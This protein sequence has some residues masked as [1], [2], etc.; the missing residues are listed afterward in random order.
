MYEGGKIVFSDGA[1]H[2]PRAA[3]NGRSPLTPM[4]DSSSLAPLS[5]CSYTATYG[6][7]VSDEVP[8]CHRGSC[9]RAVVLGVSEGNGSGIGAQYAGASTIHFINSLSPH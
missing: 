3:T 4:N 7:V 5:K 6:F 2:L 1:T 8:G 9:R